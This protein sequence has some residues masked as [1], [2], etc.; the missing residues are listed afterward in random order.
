MR[1][2]LERLPRGASIEEIKVEIKRVAELISDTIISGKKFDAFSKISTSTLIKKFGS[3]ENALIECGLGHRY[4]GRTVSAKM[5]NQV[6]RNLPNSDLI[7]ELKKIAHKLNKKELS[8]KDFNENSN[9]SASVIARRFGSW[10]EGLKKA[11]LEEVKMAKRYT[12]QDYF[13]NLLNVW[14]HYGRQPYY[15]EIDSPPS[16]ISSGAYEGRWGKWSSALKAFIEFINSD[17]P[18]N[19]NEETPRKKEKVQI[20]SVKPE[21]KNKRDIPLGLRYSVL[22]RD[23]F[24]CVKCGNSP[25]SDLNCKLHIDHIIPFSK[26][27]LTTLENLQTACSNCNLGKGN[28]HNE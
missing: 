10:S 22:S 21:K 7:N 18:V 1:F 8:Q 9:F 26:G 23:R 28:R 6:A 13:E 25:A 11:G 19:V 20:I 16:I 5:R 15:R 3:W 12:E 14:T 27:G 17:N 4:S 2:E 24:R